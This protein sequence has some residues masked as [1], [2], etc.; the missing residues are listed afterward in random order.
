MTPQQIPEDPDFA[1]S[2]EEYVWD[3]LAEQLP[4]E[5][6]MIFGQRITANRHEVEI[7]IL[8]LWPGVGTIVM[9]VKGGVVEVRDGEWFQSRRQ[10][11][12]S[13]VEQARLAKHELNTF[14]KGRLSYGIGKLTHVIALPYT[15]LDPKWAVPDAPRHLV[16]DSTDVPHLAGF[17]RRAVE[18]EAHAAGQVLTLAQRDG[19][20]KALRATHRAVLNHQELAA[21]I[22]DR[23]NELTREQ[24]RVLSLL[25]FQHRAQLIGGAGSGKTHLALMK[26][27]ELTRQGKRVALVCYSRG[28]ARHFQLLVQTWPEAERPLFV[29]LFHDLPL[30]LDAEP[31]D[32]SMGPEASYYDEFLPRRLRELAQDLPQEHRFEGIVVDEAQDFADAWWDGLMPLLVGGPD[33]TLFAFADSHQEVFDRGGRA[34]IDLSPFPLDENLRN[35]ATIA[36]CFAPLTPLVQRPRLDPG[37]PIVWVPVTVGESVIGAADDAV[38]SVLSDD[39]WQPGQVALLTTGHRH[40]M[41]IE[42]V[43]TMGHEG[44]WDEFFAASDVFYGH[45]LGFKGLERDVVVLALDGSAEDER[46]V[47][48]LYVGLSRARAQLVVVGEPEVLRRIGGDEVFNRICNGSASQ[49]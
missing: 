46:A 22:A 9:E 14:L 38:E 48:K 33:G 45:V 16:A 10:L 49:R 23:G 3:A 29:G 2:A 31:Y 41:Q 42:T 36:A 40:P 21:R 8:V 15:R 26:A 24:E 35:S 34:P 32:P 44:Y 6:T 11:K 1:S 27:R 43:E 19:V 5:A 13:P 28:L 25:R 47:Q 12:K 4:P 7:D 18:Q 37:V 17:L 30:T 39:A 20:V